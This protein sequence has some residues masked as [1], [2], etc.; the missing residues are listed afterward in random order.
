MLGGIRYEGGGGSDHGGDFSLDEFKDWLKDKALDKALE[1]LTES[2]GAALK[3][4]MKDITGSI[5]SLSSGNLLQTISV[6]LKRPYTYEERH[7]EC[8]GWIF[9]SWDWSE[10]ESKSK[11]IY[12]DWDKGKNATFIMSFQGKQASADTMLNLQK[13]LKSST[14][15][16]VKNQTPAY[17][18][19]K[20]E[21]EMKPCTKSE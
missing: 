14:N 9:K 21:E 6:R 8:T 20:F 18:D 10:W 3:G 5:D 1:W 2:G 19:K 12:G 13:A 16:A 4:L 17:F 15:A 7:C 11:T